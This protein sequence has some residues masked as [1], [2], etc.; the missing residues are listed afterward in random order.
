MTIT[1]IMSNNRE[2]CWDTVSGFFVIR[3]HRNRTLK[4]IYKYGLW[5]TTS[6]GKM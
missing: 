6:E 4:K 1:D 3:G 2:L 5:Y